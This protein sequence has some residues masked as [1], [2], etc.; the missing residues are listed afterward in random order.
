MFEQ[1]LDECD[2]VVDVGATYDPK[3]HRYDHHQR[4]FND[5]LNSV[6]PDLVLHKFNTIR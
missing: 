5:T 2:I 3:K 6:R 4:G 1:V